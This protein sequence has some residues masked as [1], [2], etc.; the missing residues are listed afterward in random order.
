MKQ[1]NIR[2]AQKTDISAMANLLNELFA[3]ENDFQSNVEK[4]QQGLQ[5]L[6]NSNQAT[7]LVA[8]VENQVI[9]MCSVQI[10]IS[11][12]QGSKVGLI[13]DVIVTKEWRG[14][15]IGFALLKAV[16]EWAKERGL[17]RLQLLADKTNQYALDF[18]QKGD[19]K[20]TQLIALRFLL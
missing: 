16:K 9:A 14:K 6:L 4:Q 1:L 15:G 10:L 17:T 7:L 19:W 2:F 3:I 18:Y 8:E 13:E 12:A 20:T 11:T 5:L